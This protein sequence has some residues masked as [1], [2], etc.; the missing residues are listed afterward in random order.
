[1][2]RNAAPRVG[3]TQLGHATGTT[4]TAV[5]DLVRA[6]N[7]RTRGYAQRYYGLVAQWDQPSTQNT[8]E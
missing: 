7:T 2:S 1:M 3:S 4:S 5:I 6:R 8:R